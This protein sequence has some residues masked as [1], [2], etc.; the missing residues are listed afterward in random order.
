[1]ISKNLEKNREELKRIFKNSSDLIIYE[2]DT[3]CQ[4]NSN[5]CIY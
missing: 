2:F 3:L 5:G 4:K 1:M